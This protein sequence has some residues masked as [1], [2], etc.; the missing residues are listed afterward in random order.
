MSSDRDDD[1]CSHPVTSNCNHQVPPCIFWVGVIVFLTSGMGRGLDNHCN[2]TGHTTT[3]WAEAFAVLVASLKWP[4]AHWPY[5][6][7]SDEQSLMS[8]DSLLSPHH[9]LYP[10]FWQ[11]KADDEWDERW[12]APFIWTMHVDDEDPGSIKVLLINTILQIKILLTVSFRSGHV[13]MCTAADQ[14]A[15]LMW[16]GYQ[17]IQTY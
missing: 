8:P 17:I 5:L 16:R 14:S 15:I 3:F 10:V 13:F 7:S 9:H 6:P 12:P 1:I 2:Y 11:H 4:C